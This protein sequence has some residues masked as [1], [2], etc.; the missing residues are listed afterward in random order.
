MGW[1]RV[2]CEGVHPITHHVLHIN[3]R[4]SEGGAAMVAR[5]L[6]DAWISA[7][8]DAT[9]L[10]GYGPSAGRSPL[11]DP[12]QRVQLTSRP[13][14]AANFASSRLF[15]R[16]LD[17]MTDESLAVLRSCI[18]Q[19]DLVHLHCIHSYFVGTRRILTE[20]ERAGLPVVWTLHDSW[21]MTGR[22]AIPGPTSDC[23]EWRTGCQTCPHLGAYPAALRQ[24]TRREFP[25]RRE[26]IAHLQDTVPTRMVPC[27][28][29]LGEHARDAG[30][31]NIQ[32][33]HNSVDP[34]FWEALHAPRHREGPSPSNRIRIVML[35]RDLSDQGKVNRDVVAAVGRDPR[36]DLLLVGNHRPH[37]FDGIPHRPAVESREELVAVLQQA[38]R[39]LYTSTVDYFPLT[40]AEGLAAGLDVYA[41]D[42]KAAREFQD[43]PGMHVI[44]GAVDLVR[45]VTENEPRSRLRPAPESLNPATMAEQYFNLYREL[46]DES[47]QR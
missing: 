10:F 38:D 26:L 32:V 21:T 11:A 17:F 41:L 22:C 37:E 14:A 18:G 44:P 24:T 30:L 34:E 46:I 12:P 20:I 13:V 27:A 5:G 36:V 19:A 28:T 6:M 42:A 47:S 2:A 4:L 45:S 25:R 15:G 16:D 23:D 1:R 35:A 39:M 29:W 31:Q 40:V 7:G 9:F 3:V 33:I 43:L 8:G